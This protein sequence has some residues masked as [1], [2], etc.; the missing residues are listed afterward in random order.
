[1]GLIKTIT[2]SIGSVISTSAGFVNA[3]IRG[4]QRQTLSTARMATQA[5]VL[6]TSLFRL[7]TA[8]IRKATSSI[9]K[10]SSNSNR[11]EVSPIKNSNN[12]ERPPKKTRREKQIERAKRKEEI[13]RAKVEKSRQ[14]F[15][16][17]IY[18]EDNDHLVPVGLT[19]EETEK[20]R[21]DN[22]L[23]IP[24]GFYM[25]L[26]DLEENW[27]DY[28]RE[29]GRGGVSYT[30]SG[31]EIKLHANFSKLEWEEYMHQTLK[32]KPTFAYSPDEREALLKKHKLERTKLIRKQQTITIKPS[33]I[34]NEN[35]DNYLK[36]CDNHSEMLS[37]MSVDYGKNNVPFLNHL[38]NCAEILDEYGFF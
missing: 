23:N 29:C 20:L 1:M 37:R 13:Q 15:E 33:G 11:K 24:T 9:N 32:G 31:L 36:I 30:G 26:T 28:I 35:G 4:K 12:D 17:V 27:E 21:Y 5:T 10:S 7:G 18:S 22:P 19:K 2:R 34:Y 3:T 14:D 25:V 38:F 16:N 8:L 6:A